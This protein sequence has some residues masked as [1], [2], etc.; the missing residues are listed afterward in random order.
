MVDINI[1]PAIA[2]DYPE[3]DELYAQVDAYH[4]EG[5]PYSFAPVA[6]PARTLELIQASIHDPNQD[7]FVAQI[8]DRTVGLLR[9]AYRERQLPFV[10]KFIA[11]VEE[12]IVDRDHRGTGIGR[13]LMVLADQIAFDRGAVEVRLDV[14]EFNTSAYGFYESL[15][16]EPYSR[17]MR[18]ELRD[19]RQH[20]DS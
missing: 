19:P 1:R 4:H 5:A 7:L 17:W 3:L 8:E 18:K 9:I 11:I 16:F 10:P 20:D 12:I 2:A 6:T 14:L 15:G 13:Q